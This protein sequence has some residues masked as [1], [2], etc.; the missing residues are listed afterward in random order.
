MRR[1]LAVLLSLAVVMSAAPAYAALPEGWYTRGGQLKRTSMVEGDFGF[2]SPTE[3]FRLNTGLSA[4]QALNVDG[5]IYHMGGNALYEIDP[6]VASR[7]PNNEEV[8][9]TPGANPG[10]RLLATGFNDCVGD[11]GVNYC[12]VSGITDLPYRPS[13]SGLTYRTIN[14]KRVLYFGTGANQVCAF[15]LDRSYD[16]PNQLRCAQLGGTEPIVSTPLV[17]EAATSKGPQDVVIIGDK[18]GQV[19]IIQNLA[20]DGMFLAQP[21]WLGGWVTSSPSWSGGNLEFVV[22]ADGT[23]DPR[24]NGKVVQWTVLAY[25]GVCVYI[26]GYVHNLTGLIENRE[27]ANHGNCTVTF[28]PVAD[29]IAGSFLWYGDYAEVGGDVPNTVSTPILRLFQM[30]PGDRTKHMELI[31]PRR[32]AAGGSGLRRHMR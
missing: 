22:A 25:S 2:L 31:L 21:Y 8:P 7:Y 27:V 24:G 20:G 16:D 1:V 29:V 28:M 18:A 11:N 4:S 12:A 6:L 9:P 15:G 14:G 26:M 32:F 13:S 10:V 17:F 5:K 3:S 30:G 19:W 23:G